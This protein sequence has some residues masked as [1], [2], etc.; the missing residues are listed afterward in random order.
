MSS[1]FPAAPEQNGTDHWNTNYKNDY[2]EQGSNSNF[3]SLSVRWSS[4]Q[5]YFEC[6]F[7]VHF[8]LTSVSVTAQCFVSWPVCYDRALSW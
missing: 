1:I 3:R 2:I 4:Y 6:P 8:Y 5:D 7:Q